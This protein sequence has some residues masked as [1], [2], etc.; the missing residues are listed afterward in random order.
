MST[1]PSTAH[2]LE[3]TLVDLAAELNKVQARQGELALRLIDDPDDQA[4]V[5]DLA[6]VD[7]TIARLR[8]R[9]ELFRNAYRAALERDAQ[10]AEATRVRGIVEARDKAVQAAHARV[11]AAAQVDAAFEALRVAI[12]TYE[13]LTKIVEE[14]ARAVTGNVFADVTAQIRAWEHVSRSAGARCI[15][16]GVVEG[17]LEAGV[18]HTRA[19]I[20]LVT[21]AIVARD[22]S[23][24]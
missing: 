1:T 17:V 24:S 20:V 22:R 6:T 8:R 21:L 12:E 3:R 11:A 23:G 14:N 18:G 16:A 10:S 7:D 15:A 13:G 2:T 5:D 19:R 4:V 9:E